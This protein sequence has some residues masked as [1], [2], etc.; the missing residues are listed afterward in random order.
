MIEPA[1]LVNVVYNNSL[2]ELKV[3]EYGMCS[4]TSVVDW[5]YPR[6]TVRS[7]EMP[8]AR[9]YVCQLLPTER[10]QASMCESQTNSSAE[11][12]KK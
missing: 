9:K 4:N 2:F 10:K 1:H 6:L 3:L 8:P 12:T 7:I 5:A 11:L